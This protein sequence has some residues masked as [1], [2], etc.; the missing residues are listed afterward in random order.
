[1]EKLTEGMQVEII[2][3]DG[4]VHGAIICQINHKTSSVS[5]EW[6]EKGETKGK[7]VDFNALV[8]YNPLIFRTK[9]DPPEVPV[10]NGDITKVATAKKQTSSNSFE[11][12]T[13]T[14]KRNGNVGLSLQEP[15]PK[16]NR[17]KSFPVAPIKINF[18]DPEHFEQKETRTSKVEQNAVSKDTGKAQ[19]TS[20]I[21]DI[22]KLVVGMN[23]NIKRSDG[24]IHGALVTQIARLT[25]M[26]SVEWFERGET[27]GKDIELAA[28]IKNNPELF[29][30]SGLHTS[31]SRQSISSLN[32]GQTQPPTTA[33]SSAINT[34]VAFADNDK[35]IGERRRTHAIPNVNNKS[36]KKEVAMLG[37]IDENNI[38]SE[39]V[40]FTDENQPNI[41][42][43][44]AAQAS[45]RSKLLTNIEDMERNREQRRVQQDVARKQRELQMQIDP[46]NPHWEFLSM[47]R[48]YQSQLVYRPLRITDS[49]LDNRICVCVR[50]R[51]LSKKELTGKEVEVVTIPNKDRVI[52]HQPQTKVDL[53]KYLV[54]QQFK[55]DYTFNENSSN[56][57]VYKFS[58][59][60]LVRTIFQRGFAT[61]FAYGQTGS[62]KTHTMGGIIEGKHLDCSAGIYAMTANDVFA[63]LHSPEYKNE[64]LMVACS[65][66]EIYGAM[67][68]DLLNKKA[69]LRVLEDAKRVVQVVG[70]K[71]L[72]VNSVEDVL[73]IIKLGSNQRTA[74]QTS[75]N[76]NSSRSHAVFQIILRKREK[77]EDAL[78]GKFS[79]IDLA[80]NE[81]GADTISSD[82]QTRLEGAEINKSLLAL[83]ECIRAM[84][85]DEQHIPFRGSKLT[86]I[87]RD[88]FVGKY[89]KTC[90]IAMISPGISCVENTMNTLRYA[91][92]VKELGGE[93]DDPEEQQVEDDENFLWSDDE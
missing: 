5:V 40:H 33:S 64:C 55:F 11:P 31:R 3:S 17:Q 72:K 22:D 61:C 65:F 7:E 42:A 39:P 67:V 44:S 56:E 76:S 25:G 46:G 48:D 13:K 23:V 15:T 71:E 84:G 69:K 58:A 29:T 85:R 57:L 62:G 80:G 38:S 70:L 28:I 35:T 75:A 52:V 73:K 12:K 4:R 51:P 8:K 90:M 45:R 79:L 53:T 32:H 16:N 49:V 1:M 74:G 43:S 20:K 47:I 88:S 77:N 41:P 6:F 2:R 92:R 50:K 10:A 68:F 59:Q 89:A 87:L 14:N 24:R 83:K 27:K 60:P 9:T 86:L 26:I 91:D 30:S 54:N 82:R 78:Y 63:L 37:D 81:R 34:T 93:R 19:Q 66:F 21:Q 18:H 36:D